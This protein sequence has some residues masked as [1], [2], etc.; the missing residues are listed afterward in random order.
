MRDD[1]LNPDLPK[2]LRERYLKNQ[3]EIAIRCAERGDDL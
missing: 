2:A 3:V 1:R